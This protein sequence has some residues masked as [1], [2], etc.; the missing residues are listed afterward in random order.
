MKCQCLPRGRSHC[1]SIF[2]GTSL[3]TGGVALLFTLAA[4]RV[5]GQSA[6]PPVNGPNT[7]VETNYHSW[8][9]VV[10]VNNGLV[11]ALVNPTDGRVQQF[12]FVG[13]TDGALWENSQLYGKAPGGGFGYNNFGGD[14]A[15]PSPQ[16]AWG[17]PPPRGFDGR[18]NAVSLSNGVVTLVTQVDTRYKI[19]VTRNIE[20]LINQ[21]VMRIT[22]IFERT[23]E[24]SQTSNEL[25]VWI[26]CQA[27]VSSD[28][29][30]YVPVPSPSIFT[31]GYTTTGSAQFTAVL[32]PTFTNT[33]GLI[34]FS[35]PPAGNQKL[36]FDGG[37]LALV[38]TKLDLR[39]DAPRVP[40]ATYPDGNSSTEVYTAQGYFELEMLGPL[41]QLPV[42]GKMQF[43][44]IYS[45]FRRTE[46][47]PDA[48]A[49]KVLSWHY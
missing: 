32:P 15:W 29:R 40:G 8:T 13:D 6:R 34:S 20:L 36:G 4:A 19:Q 1:R 41:A 45:L 21:P 26:D 43:V 2:I 5:Q 17:W 46:P 31:N 38:G 10:S 28:S 12:R 27:A 11:E 7:A 23:A 37:T 9:N 18:A 39:V 24:T 47:T 42:G 33:N 44:T 30:C 14:K 48:E 35:M 3:L 49:Q 25:G 16:S 22:T